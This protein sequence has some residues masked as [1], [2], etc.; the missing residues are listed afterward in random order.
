MYFSK[1]KGH[2]S[3]LSFLTERVV[4]DEFNGTFLFQGP[5]GVGKHTTA[6]V[7]SKYLLCV[8][9]KDDTCRCEVCRLYPNVPDYLEID[10]DNSI[11]VEDID[12]IENFLS[13]IPS[14][15]NKRVVILNDLEKISYS[16][17]NGL[18]KIFEDL[19]DYATIIAISS[20]PQSVLPTVL[21]RAS[22]VDFGTLSPQE[23][24]EI[25]KSKG[26][27]GEKLVRLSKAIPYLSQSI[28]NDFGTY[29]DQLKEV[30]NFIKNFSTMDE[31]DLMSLVTQKDQEQNLLHFTEALILYLNDIMKVH[32]DS[33]EVLVYE[34]KLDDLVQAKEILSDEI[35]LAF[36]EKIRKALEQ[37]NRGVNVNLRTRIL[38]AFLWSYTLVQIEKVKNKNESKQN[39]S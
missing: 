9:T 5:K 1:I 6:Q 23:Y 14:K 28:L 34:D 29:L 30:P 39:N 15:S 16:A 36:I 37:F 2:D 3:V 7:L 19:K 33:V 13:L 25:L 27:S 4:K 26:H 8:G 10:N 20:N 38:S 21:S 11:K 12:K 35:C 18:L 32:Y 22:S 17:A 24:L 31:D